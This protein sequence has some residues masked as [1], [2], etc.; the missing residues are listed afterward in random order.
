MIFG[1]NLLPDTNP[2]S[3]P[4]YWMALDELKEVKAQLKDLLDKGFIRSSI[5]VLGSPVMFVKNKDDSFRVCIDYREL[6]KVTI[7]N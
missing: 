1:I 5:S 6:N 4:P 3:I 2:I 7:E